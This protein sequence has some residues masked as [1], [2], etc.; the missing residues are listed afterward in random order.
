MYFN[1]FSSFLPFYLIDVMKMGG[2]DPTKV[3]FNL[4]LV[5]MLAYI[6]S[7]VVTARL[8]W[9]YENIGRKKS[10]FLGTFICV[11]CLAVMAVL[12]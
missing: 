2:D 3:S 1:I 4:S 10:L 7:V 6:S 9:F 8:N 5:P 11:S 12:E